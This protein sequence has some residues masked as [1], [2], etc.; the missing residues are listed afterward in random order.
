MSLTTTVPASSRRVVRVGL[1]LSGRGS[2]ASSQEPSR[3]AAKWGRSAPDTCAST[4]AGVSP[5]LVSDVLFAT[6]REQTRHLERLRDCP[7]HEGAG[8]VSAVVC[9]GAR[10]LC[11]G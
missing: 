2:V 4:K 7:N 6:S 11:V 9:L 10:R 5:T 1:P 8:V 3:S